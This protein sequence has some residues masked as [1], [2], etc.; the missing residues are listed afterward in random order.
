MSRG[1]VY[2]AI[3]IALVILRSTT[4]AISLLMSHVLKMMVTP[5]N[6]VSCRPLSSSF[7]LSSLLNLEMCTAAHVY[8]SYEVVT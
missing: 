7:P 3:V 1:L 6:S 8:S 4:S 2:L 5:M